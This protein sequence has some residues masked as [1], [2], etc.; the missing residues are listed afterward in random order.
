MLKIKKELKGKYEN[1]D[2]K[3]KLLVMF[4]IFALMIM[5]L[6]SSRIDNTNKQNTIIKNNK[7]VLELLRK[8]DNN[9]S[10]DIT[11]N[12]ENHFKYSNY[13][14]LKIYNVNN[15]MYLFYK[16]QLY[17]YDNGSI[18]VSTDNINLDYYIYYGIDFIKQYIY[19]STCSEK[20]CSLKSGDLIN[21]RN[22][23]KGISYRVVDKNLITFN[24]TYSDKIEQIDVDYS[25]VQN[26]IYN[27]NKKMNYKIIFVDSED[28][29]TIYSN[30]SSYV[31]SNETNK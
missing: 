23:A 21:I 13:N 4:F 7:K 15:K 18:T 30:I 12:D 25:Y 11:V 5:F 19:N 8:V 6:I 29:S 31:E 22:K 20:S 17:E 16:N 24:L 28:Y 1:M 27:D 3:T 9:Y 26:I 10:L 2:N 14:D